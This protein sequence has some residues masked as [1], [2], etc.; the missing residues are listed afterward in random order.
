MF[1]GCEFL[2]KMPIYKTPALT[3]KSIRLGESGK[4]VTF[5]TL[6]Y[7][8]IKAVAKGSLK[9]KSRFMG[10]LEP[11]LLVN[12]IVFAKERAELFSLNSCDIIEPFISLRSDLN[13][14]SL[15]YV[16][17][18]LVDMCQ[19]D[20]DVNRQGFDSLLTLWRM[21]NS[22]SDRGKP[23]GELLLRLF[24][25][26]YIASIGFGPVLTHCIDCNRS[27]YGSEI[28][29]NAV[30]GGTVCASCLPADPMAR[31]TVMGAV[32]LMSR[33]L[34]TP[35]D[36]L[37]RLSAVPSIL[38]EI[39]RMVNDLVAVHAPRKMRSEFFLKQLSDF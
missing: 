10:R 15:A 9:P 2:H 21:L 7:G 23:Q 33:G 39:E 5:F 34:V 31:R 37:S 4:L 18:E 14:M 13:S 35:M 20:R 30:K 19:R 22:N 38:A 1:L 25:L 12:L 32:K 8:K 17:A 11:F 27:L 36:K 16:S 24:E 28:G 3:L 26:K 29:F 6:R